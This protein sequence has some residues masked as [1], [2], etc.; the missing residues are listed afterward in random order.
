MLTIMQEQKIEPNEV[1]KQQR[2]V[3]KTYFFKQFS[4]HIVRHTLT[5]SLVKMFTYT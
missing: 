4:S 1:G 3:H 2:I 5:F